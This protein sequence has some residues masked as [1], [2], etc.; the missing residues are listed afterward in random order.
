L[1]GILGDASSLNDRLRARFRSALF[2][3]SYYVVAEEASAK[4]SA[5]FAAALADRK[6]DAIAN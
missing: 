3:S 1:N 4:L 5:L 2:R 6:L